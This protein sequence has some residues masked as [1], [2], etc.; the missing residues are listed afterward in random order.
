MESQPLHL[1]TPFRSY[2]NWDWS[3]AVSDSPADAIY[4]PLRQN[5][6][7]AGIATTPTQ[8]TV[9]EENLKVSQQLMMNFAL[10]SLF[11][12][13]VHAAVDC[14]ISFSSAELGSWLGAYSGFT[15]Y[16][17]YT[18]SSLI[19]AKWTM[20]WF[21][22]SK[23][24][25]LTGLLCLC[26]Y[27]SAFFLAL[28]LPRYREAVF[29]TGAAI[30]GVGAGLLWTSQG[31]YYTV[32]AS[33]FSYHV[34]V[35]MPDRARAVYNFAALFATFYLGVEAAMQFLSTTIA[36]TSSSWRPIVFGAY[37]AAAGLSLLLFW[38][39]VRDFAEEEEDERRLA[40]TSEDEHMR[41]SEIDELMDEDYDAVYFRS[42]HITRRSSDDSN[43]R[44]PETLTS[45]TSPIGADSLSDHILAVSRAIL[46]VRRLQLLLPYQMSFGLSA[47]LVQSYVNGVIVKDNVGEGYIGLLSGLIPLTAVAI[48]QPL[49]LLATSFSSGS[50]AIMLTGALCFAYGGVALLCL[51]NHVIAQWP[52]LV[53]Y[54]VIHGVAR[55]VWENTNKAVVADFFPLSHERDVAFAAIYFASGLAGALGFCLVQL[56][57]RDILA[58]IN[59][60][61]HQHEK[62]HTESHP[63]PHWW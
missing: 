41:Q 13:I 60:A 32:N 59:T 51:S 35:I 20:R 2:I 3:L 63:P 11:Y 37:S 27:V 38:L 44:I 7:S 6:V 10:F 61:R 18:L 19:C 40:H 5:N 43:N 25:V 30:G 52:V 31:V 15:L 54:Y 29:L 42:D 21:A 34:D 48:A 17:F 49:A 55:G 4:N 16:L 58:L 62:K 57:S 36:L 46:S 28:L 8:V 23:R 33:L 39:T 24:V 26:L 45:S 47:G 53:L 14:V 50:R 1:K 12:S 56:L 9:D 22:S